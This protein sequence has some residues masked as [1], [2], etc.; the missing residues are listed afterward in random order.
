MNLIWEKKHTKERNLCCKVDLSEFSDLS[1]KCGSVC[2]FIK[3]IL[4]VQTLLMLL[5]TLV[6]QGTVTVGGKVNFKL[7]VVEKLL[8]TPSGEAL[9]LDNED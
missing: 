2:A 4:H 6:W 9:H 8:S 5:T 7:A 1:W 3:N